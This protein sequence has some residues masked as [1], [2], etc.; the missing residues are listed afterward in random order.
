V[1]GWLVDIEALDALRDRAE[2]LVAAVA[3][4]NV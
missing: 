3:T 1:G 4:A 2:M